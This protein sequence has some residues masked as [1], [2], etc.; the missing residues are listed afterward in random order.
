MTQHKPLDFFDIN[1]K[2]GRCTF[3]PKRL[4]D[5]IKE[6]TRLASVGKNLPI[7]FYNESKGVWVDQGERV[8]RNRSYELLDEQ[9]THSRV[10]EVVHYIQDTTYMD[11]DVFNQDPTRLPVENGTLDL[12]TG[13]LEEHRPEL[14][15]ITYLPRIYDP[16]KDCPEF[17][18][19]LGQSSPPTIY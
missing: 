3:I 8:I 4:A 15:A 18:K 11:L 5:V 19:F 1:E 10:E 16:I 12:T 13:E 14:Y 9:G 6:E 17:R 7:M 2:T